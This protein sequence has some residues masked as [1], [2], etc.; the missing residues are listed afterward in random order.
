MKSP[1]ISTHIFSIVAIIMISLCS[2]PL[3]ARQL[4]IRPLIGGVTLY[5]VT[6][7]TGISA[8]TGVDLATVHWHLVTGAT[9][10][11]IKRSDTSGGGYV[12]V[13]TAGSGASSYIDR[14][15][16]GGN[17][18]YY[19]V[20]ASDSSGEGPNSVEISVRPAIDPPT[21]IVATQASQQVTL[22]WNAAANATSY[23]IYRSGTSG[24]ETLYQSGVGAT[25]FTDTGLTNGT[26]YFYEITSSC[27]IDTSRVSTEI[28]GIPNVVLGAPTNVASTSP[29]NV[30]INL[31]WT[32]VSG[33]TAYTIYRGLSSGG[34]GTSP[35]STITTNTISMPGLTG[36]TDYFFLV[37]AVNSASTSAASAE[38]SQWTRPNTPTGVVAAA[39]TDQATLSWSAVPGATTYNVRRSTVSGSGYLTVASPAST[40]YTDFSLTGGTTYY[41]IIVANNSGGLS[42]NSAEVNARPAI[43]P[44]TSVSAAAGVNQVTVTWAAAANA[45]AYNIYAGTS[46]GTE[47]LIA[48]GASGTSYTD[49]GLT[50]GTAYYFMVQSACVVDS[51]A[52][53][54]EVSATPQAGSMAPTN[55][56]ASGVSSSQINLSWSAAVGATTYKIYRGTTPGGEGASP[57]TS[58]SNTSQSMPGLSDGTYYYFTVRAVGASGTSGPSNEAS[59]TTR[60]LPPASLT[61]TAGT[62]QVALS[63]PAC[64][65]A[66]AYVVGRSLVSGGPYSTAGTTTGT[67]LTD[68]G[69]QGGTTYYYMIMANDSSGSSVNSV[70]ASARPAIDPPT[71]VSA[72]PGVSQVT[73]TWTAAANATSYNIYSGTAAGGESPTPVSSGVS[74]TTFTHTGLTNGMAYYYTVQSVC[75][76]DSSAMS[77]EVSSTP[78]GG[79]M[80]PTN[81]T[82][83]GVSSSQINLSWSAA[84]GATTYKIY[85]GATP[86]G[87]GASPVASTSNTSQSIPGLSDGTY[88]YFTVRAVSASGTSAPSAEASATTRCLPP[89]SLTAT[90]G[91]DQVS[92]SWPA[93][94]GATTYVVGRSQTSGGPYVTA[95]TTISPSL[96]DTGLQ[97]GT[98]YYY[99]VQANDAGGASTNS[100]EASARPAIDPPSGVSASPGVNQV[101]ITWTAAA[102]ATSYS[103][104]SGTAAGAEGVS[105]VATGVTGSSYT[106]TGLTVGS[107]YFYKV[108]SVCAV[109]TS[110]MS[111]EVSASPQSGS[112]APTNLA[113][114]GVSP[115]QINLTWTAAVGATNYRVY[116]GTAPGAEGTT[117]VTTTANTHQSLTAMAAGTFYY[118]NVRA[119]SASGTSAPCAEA[120]ATTRCLPP[121]SL[122]TTAGT[123]QV[124]LTW[125]A[126]VGATAYVVG[127]SATTGG[128][129]TTAGTV[130]ATS[131]IDTGLQ[132]G[133]TYFYMI[134][135]N[136]ASGSS[137]NSVEA[138]AR[139][140]IDP[141]S[142]VSASP[143]VNQ[144]TITWTAAANATS[145][146]IYRGTA[147]GGESGTALATGITGTSYTDTGLTVGTTYFYTMQSVCAV[148]TSIMSAEASASPQAG[149]N[150]PTNVTATGVSTVQINLKWTA[151]VG[152]TNYKIYRGTTAGGE[153][154]SPVTS[155]SNTNQ[156]MPGLAAGTFYYFTIRAVSAA[157]TSP[158]SAEASATTRCLPPASLTAT[159]GQDQ[160]ALSWP[161]CTGATSYKIGR[162]LVSGGPYS[163]AGTTTSATTFTD[164]GLLGGTLYYYVVYPVNIAAQGAM[165]PQAS[166]T[167]LIDVPGAAAASPMS[168]TDIFVGWM[169]SI[170]AT[171]YSLERS[172]DG[173]SGWSVLANQAATT[174]DDTNLQPGTTY[175]YRVT[176]TGNGMTTAY[177]PVV[178]G[179][180][181]NTIATGPF[182]PVA[183]P[184]DQIYTPTAAL[185]GPHPRWMFSNVSLATLQ[186]RASDPNYANYYANLL[187][188]AQAA[189]TT[190]P[191]NPIDPTLLDPTRSYGEGL[192]WMSL[193]YLLDPDPNNQALY[194]Q[195]ITNWVNA[196]ASSSI[197]SQDL[198][199]DYI[200][201]GLASTYDWL[202]NVLPQSTL[203]TI[204]STLI[205]Y[206]NYLQDPNNLTADGWV[207]GFYEG[208]VN[209]HNWH[210]YAAQAVAAVALY[211]ETAAPLQAGQPA[212][213]LDQSMQNFWYVNQSLPV[214]GAPIEGWIYQ[215]YALRAYCD[216][217]QIATGLCSTNTDFAANPMLSAM[218][219][220]LESML[221]SGL[222][223]AGYADSEDTQTPADHPYVFRYL[224]H[225]LQ[226]NKIQTL[227]AYMEN[228]CGTVTEKYNWRDMFYADPSVPTTNMA[229]L[230]LTRDA[231]DLGLFTIRSSWNANANLLSFKC[232]PAAAQTNA[233]LWGPT[234]VSS[235]DHPDEGTFSFFAGADPIVITD[236]SLALKLSQ[237]SN[238]TIFD[239]QDSQAGQLVGQ[240]GEGGQW[241]SHSVGGPY[242][243]ANVTQLPHVISVQHTAAYT[244]YLCDIGGVYQLSDSRVAG[245][246]FSPSYLRCVTYL[247]TGAVVVADKIQCPQPRNMHFRI[248]TNAN[249]PLT[250]A[251]TKYSF[252]AGATPATITD[253]SP[254]AWTHNSLTINPVFNAPYN[255]YPTRQV[256]DIT[257][258]GQ[259]NA[260]F[261]AAVRANG[262]DPN[263]AVSATQG[264]IAIT[265]TGGATINLAW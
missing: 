247:S 96:I 108:Q 219:G 92:L 30:Q 200:I 187:A 139:P 206:T 221:P 158:P 234:V 237:F 140:A 37:R 3:S 155:T 228:R 149:S 24:T 181:W 241:F 55:V 251:G 104:Y 119:V 150:I 64:T 126:C 179:M 98:T 113:A 255:E 169:P 223:F 33:A 63:W 38:V 20:S 59:A 260:I 240:L 162:S 246:Q 56:T 238:V 205:A 51:S 65:G 83:S 152:A 79:S 77:A 141:P 109:D 32:A 47:S 161:A 175:Y 128:P 202:Y 196:F 166:A 25:S 43:D 185:S 153:G 90:A 44:P 129:Y 127:R 66:T 245:G 54:A 4:F 201:I 35:I 19:V 154:A 222:G 227:A 50:N 263:L 27:A 262:Q 212:T 211:G 137:T 148:D 210:L 252:T 242:S 244:S 250:F 115:S 112:M 26:S 193:A 160:I 75:A 36:G 40:S 68:T 182:D 132:G 254:T 138:T 146:K 111:A 208:R 21:G 48:S 144:V 87:E 198:A 28:K 230:P 256:A 164:T 239:G 190:T 142:G 226:D 248:Q 99:M 131:F 233:N 81:L 220:R 204:R 57:V 258:T 231:T 135:A 114:V 39:G 97:G 67:T 215:P 236:G 170:S 49:T 156:S 209:N 207:N 151:A 203:S 259:T 11:N 58:T 93:C 176:A 102:N 214:D 42:G 130:T 171:S 5:A 29:S 72:S 13:G 189:A 117:P 41:Y 118:F 249:A 197:N 69:L 165:S 172:P 213:W 82:A 12:V 195:G 107:T 265:P 147:A 116:R 71:G 106:N 103:V 85:R 178:K 14:N 80:A 134:M 125:P 1:R 225:T 180:T 229:C 232:G 261:A 120:S 18:Y 173:I 133:S 163:N 53:S 235:H 2:L 10:Y 224:A 8:S 105:P 60:C 194:L 89:A 217:S 91:T 124:T 46:P 52:M 167:T 101:T 257:A 95:G 76:V 123:D 177:T 218:S 73:L 136:D 253:F 243:Y 74:G 22:S 31:S 122:T 191:P 94:N 157:G 70:E 88:Y 78:Q 168:A 7:P 9:S 145:Y 6:A 183:P 16:T 216:F 192:S 61:A 45:T 188:Q 199:Q 62:D 184:P 34:E 84:V 86:G 174:F 186:Q 23:Q 17:T 159:A 110:A 121:A 264:N 143:G 100:V 15:L